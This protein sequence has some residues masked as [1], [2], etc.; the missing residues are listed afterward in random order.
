MDSQRRHRGMSV[1][2]EAPSR[3]RSR[4]VALLCGATIAVAGCAGSDR[5]N[6]LPDIGDLEADRLLFE[7][8]SEA[9]D[10][11]NW[12]RAREYFLQIRDNYPQSQYRAEARLLI[13]DTYEGEGSSESYVR[14]LEEFQD[15][16]SLYPTHP[17]AGYA[18]YKLG[19]VHLHQMKRPERDQTE[20]L[21][22]ITEFEAFIERFPA[23]H[24]LMPQVR[25][26]L[27]TARDRLGMHNYR[28]GLYYYKYK[29]YAG[30]IFRFYALLEE[31]PEFSGRDAVYFY[32]AS[33][34]LDGAQK[35]EAI[36]Y[37][38]RVRDEY[39][40]SEFA[41]EAVRRLSELEAEA[42]Q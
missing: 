33:A 7:R 25:E 34:L 14:A 2:G 20:T 21:A 41:A 38:A 39:P 17:R 11:R 24:E 19:M 32:L 3:W 16:L 8:G 40:D 13:G 26:A 37:F 15:F 28:V 9:M 22:A 23:D 30:S 42:Q 1:S 6:N 5:V 12:A 10:D 18:Q 35:A 31:D 29:N 4:T 27:R 36:P